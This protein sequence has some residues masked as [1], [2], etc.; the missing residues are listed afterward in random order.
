MTPAELRRH[1]RR[2]RPETGPITR[3]LG[4]FIGVT[5][6]HPT[7]K[8]HWLRWLKDYNGPGYYG[9][10]SWDRDARAVYNLLQC[11]TMLLW[12]AEASGVERVLL[13]R[14]A[15]KVIEAGPN[16]ARQCG[17]LRR[18]IAWEAVRAALEGD[19][20]HVNKAKHA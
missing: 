7:E 14:A 18:V 20:A 2:L 16:P 4:E 19:V 1:V 11:A 13:V 6:G 8:A 17:A 15:H 9:R 12:L 3:R 5:H 10:D